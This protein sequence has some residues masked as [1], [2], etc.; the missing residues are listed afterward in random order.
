VGKDAGIYQLST[1]FTGAGV[2][3][4]QTLSGGVAFPFRGQPGR[5]I[6]NTAGGGENLRPEQNNTVEAGLE[7]RFLRDRISLD[8]AYYSSVSK[9]QILPVNIPGSTGFTNTIINAGEVTNKGVE[10][11]L[12]ATPIQT[13]AFTWQVSANF[14][15]NR[16][17][18]VRLAPGLSN[19]TLVSI[20][21][22][23]STRI[24]PGQPYGVLWGGSFLE[25]G[26]GNL[27]IDDNPTVN[28]RPNPNYGFP[29]RN[30][31][32]GIIGDP[33]PDW[34]G[35]LRNTF[36][37]KGFTLSGLLDVRYG[38][39]VWNGTRA[40]MVQSGTAKET[41]ERG[42]PKVFAGIKQNEGTPNDITVTPTQTWYQGNGGPFSGNNKPFVEDGSWVRLRELTLSYALPG[43]ILPKKF[44]SS[45]EISL[46]G[47]NLLLLT[48]YSGADPETGLRGDVNGSL[49]VDYFTNPN[50]RSYGV[51]LRISL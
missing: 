29:V 20:G 47:R 50:T 39:D 48:D 14:S 18:V 13:S 41:E 25:D 2:T 34:I 6:G 23:A 11:L 27:I 10:V 51:N 28:G 15:A 1:V 7:L 45:A 3:G 24:I 42:Q 12:T 44:I 9:D 49:G 26:N 32:D 22:L 31:Q 38:S 30:P 43:R 8:V 35:G 33:N 16:S 36:S 40:V 19:I 4:N 17:K 46:T 37:F 21:P 5:T